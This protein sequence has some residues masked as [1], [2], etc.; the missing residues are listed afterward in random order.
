MSDK[1]LEARIHGAIEC[2]K[3]GHEMRNSHLQQHVKCT[4]RKC[5]LFNKPFHI[6]TV[7]LIPKEP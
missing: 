1:P 6:P 3:C 4:H 7:T 5:E 2:P